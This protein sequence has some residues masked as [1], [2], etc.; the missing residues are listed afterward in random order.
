M[1]NNRRIGVLQ[2]LR[3]A[4]LLG[5]WFT[6]MVIV[7]AEESIDAGKIFQTNCAACHSG[8]LLEAPKVEAFK[9]YPPERI[10]KALESGLMSTAGMAL[11][12]EEKYAVAEF[13]SGKKIAESSAKVTAYTCKR[14]G[15]DM[16]RDAAD[17]VWNGWGGKTA[18]RRHQ[19]IK[20]LGLG[21]LERE[22]LTGV[23]MDVS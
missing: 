13:L 16:P 7:Q 4:T 14:A 11:S 15:I 2:G 9:L 10:V 23:T 20:V 22:T 3:S 18:N 12:R 21:G 1:A 6:N 17:S 5:L 19:D 8:A